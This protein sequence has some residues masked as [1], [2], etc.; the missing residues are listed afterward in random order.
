MVLDLAQVLALVAAKGFAAL[1]ARGSCPEALHY[2]HALRACVGVATSP[3]V[4]SPYLI[5]DLA[6]CNNLAGQ[7]LN[8]ESL[9]GDPGVY[10]EIA[11]VIKRTK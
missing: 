9:T 4:Y 7:G 8:L 3:G 2:R 5:D 10:A 1:G 11:E 6:Q